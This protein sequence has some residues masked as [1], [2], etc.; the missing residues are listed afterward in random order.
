MKKIL[1]CFLIVPIIFVSIIVFFSCGDNKLNKIELSL[2]NSYVYDKGVY[3][4]DKSESKVILKVKIGPNNYT[5]SD[6]IFESSDT[7]VIERPRVENGEVYF[8]PKSRSGL[9]TVTITA[10]YENKD[11]TVVKSNELKIKVVDF[12]TDVNFEKEIYE[13]YYSGKDIGGDYRVNEDPAFIDNTSQ[14]SFPKESYEYYSVDNKSVVNEIVNAG[15]YEITC[16]NPKDNLAITKCLLVVKKAKIKINSSPTNITFGDDLPSNVYNIN[17]LPSNILEN[18]SI[19]QVILGVEGGKDSQEKIG[20]YILTTNKKKGSSVG[21]FDLNVKIEIDERFSANYSSEVDYIKSSI[22]KLKISPK[23]VYLVGK[24]QEWIYGLELD[25]YPYSVISEKEFIDLGIGGAPLDDLFVNEV[26]LRVFE[27]RYGTNKTIV[28]DTNR[29]S[30][31]L[32]VLENSGDG[33]EDSAYEINLDRATCSSNLVILQKISGTL[34]ILPRPITMLPKSGLNKTYGEQDNLGSK[35]YEIAGRYQEVGSDDL[36]NCLSVDYNATKNLGTG[37]YLAEVGSYPYKVNNLFLN[38]NVMLDERALSSA[39]DFNKV[40]FEVM[41]CPITIELKSLNDFYKTPNGEDDLK[42]SIHTLGYYGDAN[43]YK[44]QIQSI[45][46]NKE[47]VALIA[48]SENTNSLSSTFNENGQINLSTGEKFSFSISLSK[49]SKSDYYISYDTELSEVTFA[50]GETGSKNYKINLISS[51]VNLQKISLYVRPDNLTKTFDATK[52][53]EAT[54]TYT[55]YELENGQYKQFTTDLSSILKPENNEINLLTMKVS[56]SGTP[57]TGTSGGASSRS[58]L[59]SSGSLVT[60]DKQYDYV[61]I[62]G[63]DANGNSIYLATEHFENVGKYKIFLNSNLTYLTGKE[64]F[65]F[66]LDTENATDYYYEITPLN[67]TITPKAGQGKVYGERDKALTYDPNPTSVTGSPTATGSLTRVAGENATVYTGSSNLGYKISIGSLSFG[68]NYNLTISDDVYFTISQRKVTITPYAYTYVYGQEIRKS[69]LGYD[70]RVNG[71]VYD[72]KVVSSAYP[73]Y[74]PTILKMPTFTGSLDINLDGNKI[75]GGFYPVK[76]KPVTGEI[77]SYAVT[78]GNLASNNNYLIDF[79]ET[80]SVTILKRDAVINITPENKEESFVPPEFVTLSALAN[81]TSAKFSITNLVGTPRCTLNLVLKDSNT[82]EQRTQGHYYSVDETSQN[83]TKTLTIS[84]EDVTSNYNLSFSKDAKIIYNMQ[85]AIIKLSIKH[86]GSNVCAVE[87]MGEEIDPEYFSLES[88]TQDYEVIGGNYSFKWTGAPTE[89]VDWTPKNVGD[90]VATLNTTKS[91]FN[92]MLRK[93]QVDTNGN[94]TY[95]D[96]EFNSLDSSAT[97]NNAI[98]IISNHGY[99]TISKVDIDIY[100][101]P[102]FVD[103]KFIFGSTT[104]PNLKLTNEDGSKVFKGRGT[105]LNN[106]TLKTF[107]TLNYIPYKNYVSELNAMSTT[108]SIKLTIQADSPNYNPLELQVDIKVD[109]REITV[110]RTSFKLEKGTQSLSN[111]IYDGSLKALNVDVETDINKDNYSISYKY[112]K[113]ITEYSESSKGLMNCYDYNGTD[114]PN[115]DILSKKSVSEL[116]VGAKIEMKNFNNTPYIVVGND[117]FL[118]DGNTEISAPS[119]AGIYVCFATCKLN[120]NYTFSQDNEENQT[121]TAGCIFEIEKSSTITIDNWKDSFYYTTVFD[122]ENPQTLPFEFSLYPKFDAVAFSMDTTDWPTNNILNVGR[123]SVAVIVD[124]EN[125]YAKLLKEFKVEKL[126]VEFI[127]PVRNIYS[128]IGTEGTGDQKKEIPVDTFLQDILIVQKDKDGKL[129]NSFFYDKFRE[130]CQGITFSYYN[131]ADKTTTD[132]A[133]GKTGNYRLDITYGS[134][135]ED[136]GN[137]FYGTGSFDYII[138]S[139]AFSG[140]IKISN[141]TITYNPLYTQQDLYNLILNRMFEIDKDKSSYDVKLYLG[142]YDVNDPTKNLITVN[143]KLKYPAATRNELGWLYDLNFEGDHNIC[144]VVSF[145]DGITKDYVRSAILKVIKASIAQTDFDYSETASRHVYTGYE[146]YNYISYGMGGAVKLNPNLGNRTV[147]VGGN[148]YRVY[149]KILSNGY[150]LTVQDNM[151][152][153]IFE[154]QYVY[155]KGDLVL[156]SAPIVPNLEMEQDYSVEYKVSSGRNYQCNMDTLTKK[157]RIVKVDILYVHAPKWEGLHYEKGDDVISL[158]FKLM[159][160]IKVRNTES[161]ENTNMKITRYSGNSYSNSYGVYLYYYFTNTA[162]KKQ[163]TIINAGNYKMYYGLAYAD[164]YLKEYHIED[165]FKAVRINGQLYDITE[166][167]K[168]NGESYYSP[169]GMLDFTVDRV[170]SDY[171]P[172]K[173]KEAF[174]LSDGEATLKEDGFIYVNKDSLLTRVVTDLAITIRNRVGTTG[175]YN[176]ISVLTDN[177]TPVTLSINDTE[178][179]INYIQLNINASNFEANKFYYKNKAT[180]QY[181]LASTYKTYYDGTN[182]VVEYFALE[183]YQEYGVQVSE[184]INHFKSV[185]INIKVMELNAYIPNNV[186]IIPPIEQM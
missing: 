51:R 16:T 169:L 115:M 144:F 82:E 131:K 92:I 146:I 26:S 129:V 7:S 178:K 42:Q 102:T 125:Y 25:R 71:E 54:F 33:E 72:P 87:Y 81:D 58:G 136:S 104:L 66:K 20:E 27:Y 75:V 24:N 37:N 155:K 52:D 13:T 94:V 139:R 109:P 168:V 179:V 156:N 11:G 3:K 70:V 98:I 126:N 44:T 184:D 160:R 132:T 154:I 128:Y 21:E 34:S 151:F 171:S 122:L 12:E 105:D 176:T 173:W 78:M 100:G 123:Y 185:W 159:D 88:E 147:N 56:N 86:D 43:N 29:P 145:K 138:E 114:G 74:D 99:L 69:S 162:G 23:R 15:T 161:V 28:Y 53:D 32:N 14:E 65:E 18:D 39:E 76:I 50:S 116:P 111:I 149:V 61:L 30:P 63:T 40:R 113:L 47:S 134:K 73:Q 175:T 158:H 183:I 133:P 38:Y 142:A 90:Y 157:Y 79:K 1:K 121:M 103:G 31:L 127:F 166:F 60:T 119:K 36:T 59:G 172:A 135:E 143:T 106:L 22:G 174:D 55:I 67:V 124:S 107:G 148:R 62:D 137:N 41:P 5:P 97:E 110:S 164:E 8:V 49:I 89:G 9:E 95:K 48:G 77:Q 101:T 170:S 112:F 2:P 186:Q 80:G 85:L 141:T 10:K 118:L 96:V 4:V 165:F 93:R 17:N 64:Y 35:P 182:D 120:S 91:G 84:D 153:D 150:S 167:K 46:V 130:D 181:E 57:T 180:G 83:T 45:Y 177:T 140:S 19:G 68:E 108:Q 6:L 117:W 163:E 152:N